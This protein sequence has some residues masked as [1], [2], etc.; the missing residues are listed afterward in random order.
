MYPMSARM[1]AAYMGAEPFTW[2]AELVLISSIGRVLTPTPIPI[3]D[4]SIKIDYTA[5]ARRSLSNCR[6]ADPGGLLPLGPSSTLTPFGPEAQVFA[7]MIYSDGTTDFVP[8]G[9]FPIVKAEQDSPGYIVISGDDRST[10]YSEILTYTLNLGAHNYGLDVE[11]LLQT[12]NYPLYSVNVG[13]LVVY[14]GPPM[15]FTTGDVPWTEATNLAAAG[16]CQLFCDPTG[17]VTASSVTTSVSNDPVWTFTAGTNA[18]FEAPQRYY[19]QTDGQDKAANHAIVLGSS[20][21][22]SSPIRADAF[23]LD[24]TS[25][26]FW[27]PSGYGDRPILLSQ[28]TYINTAAAAYAAAQALLFSSRGAIE[29]VTFSAAPMPCFE[30]YDVITVTSPES[31]AAGNYLI[32]SVDLPL[33]PGKMTITT[34]SRRPPPPASTRYPTAVLAT[35]P[36]GYWRLDDPPA[37]TV[38]V[39]TS[40]NG[41]SG[42]YNN[43]PVLGAP[44]LIAG[45]PDTAMAANPDN[46]TS[47]MTVSTITIT[48]SAAFTVVAWFAIS[49]ALAAQGSGGSVAQS[50]TGAFQLAVGGTTTELFCFSGNQ[51]TSSAPYADGK[52]HMFA[53]TNT[54]TTFTWYM[55]GVVVG[56]PALWSAPGLNVSPIQFGPAGT[57]DE[58]YIKTAALTAAQIAAIYQAGAFTS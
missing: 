7:G 37:S 5:A 41:H 45:D 30:A 17:V 12:V 16:G 53:L 55:D 24:P 9:V 3:V 2:G 54:G 27:N 58:A 44:G 49:K 34:Q 8:V 28:G 10:R 48:P 38:A 21:D 36:T 13:D 40:G 35:S 23:D 14:V 33:N 25:P 52:R 6:F 11:N 39:D 50:T 47:N 42:A 43:S 51:T 26:T 20:I 56:S 19:A 46:T 32:S 1:T 22:G 18:T 57:V 31:G 15:T 29:V 4:G